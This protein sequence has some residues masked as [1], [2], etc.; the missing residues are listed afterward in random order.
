MLIF[1]HGQDYDE[2]TRPPHRC[3][4][5]YSPH[6]N[7]AEVDV[8]IALGR[9]YA[10]VGIPEMLGIVAGGVSNQVVGTKRRRKLPNNRTATRWREAKHLLHLSVRLAL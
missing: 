7:L 8:D 9:T 3:V 1:S 4:L 10:P 5:H 6:S 2:W